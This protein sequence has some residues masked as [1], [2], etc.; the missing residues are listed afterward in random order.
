VKPQPLGTG[1][2]SAFGRT[3]KNY[4]ALVE[5]ACPGA[6]DRPHRGNIDCKKLYWG[7]WNHAR[8][9]IADN[10]WHG[11]VRCEPDITDE[12]AAGRGLEGSLLRWIDRKCPAEFLERPIMGFF[13]LWLIAG[14]TH[15][16]PKRDTERKT[17]RRYRRGFAPFHQIHAPRPDEHEERRLADLYR[18]G[19]VIAG[20]MLIASHTWIAMG[21][22]HKYR[23]QAELD[24]LIQ[25]GTFG[26]YKAL[27]E[28]NPERH[29]RFSTLAYRAVEW[30]IKDYLKELRRLQRHESS[31]EITAKGASAVLGVYR[32]IS[33][34]RNIFFD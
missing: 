23:D 17:I 25:E 7:R 29:C 22:A 21:I 2:P 33:V 15:D 26:L 16:D 30:A 9:C 5:A 28:F 24:D 1:R 32:S 19:H 34:E 20:N 12:Q 27:E 10:R 18:A 11:K 3:D 8:R 13:L 6:V 14:L 4:L 31:D